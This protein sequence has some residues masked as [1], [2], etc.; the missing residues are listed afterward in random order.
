MAVLTLS[1][2]KG[3]R[4]KELVFC[5]ICPVTVAAA[6]YYIRVFVILKVFPLYA[7]LT[8]VVLMLLSLVLSG[9]YLLFVRD[10]L[11]ERVRSPL[12]LLLPLLLL[13]LNM[14]LM[15]FLS[16]EYLE[17]LRCFILTSG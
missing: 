1:F 7:F 6:L 15:A 8:P 3:Y 11:G 4:G 12:P 16:R 5:Y 9:L 10:R 13:I 2:L 14:G 17:T